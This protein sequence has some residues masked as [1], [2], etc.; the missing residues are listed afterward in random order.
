[1]SITLIDLKVGKTI[2]VEDIKHKELRDNKNA[3][4]PLKCSQSYFRL[5]DLSIYHVGK[6]YYIKPS[7]FM[8]VEILEK[9]IIPNNGIGEIFLISD[10]TKLGWGSSKVGYIYSG[11]SGI[12]T[13][14]IKN[15]T[16]YHV[17]PIWHGMSFAQLVL[18]LGE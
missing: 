15:I 11:F 1:M 6:P 16:N 18:K 17:L 14:E 8:L 13:L 2:F 4:V 3:N 10:M 7:T 9:I 5:V 12:V